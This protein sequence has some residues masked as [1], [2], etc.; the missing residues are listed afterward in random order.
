MLTE[1]LALELLGQFVDT[2]KG[3]PNRVDNF[4]PDDR[5]WNENWL[6]SPGLRV[7]TDELSLHAFYSRS[8]SRLEAFNDFGFFGTSESDNRVESDEFSL[9]VD[10]SIDD[11]ALITAGAVYRDD[12]A[13]NAGGLSDNYEQAGVWALRT[14]A[15]WCRTIRGCRCG[16]S[17]V[18][19]GT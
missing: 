3:T 14:R 2:E 5:Q 17:A 6:L 18:N 16:I 8:E 11:T 4:K 13:S 19:N 1:A 7:S 12:E 15:C 9:Q 10:Y